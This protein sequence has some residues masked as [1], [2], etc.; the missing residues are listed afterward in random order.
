MKTI[1]FLVAVYVIWQILKSV[2]QSQQSKKPENIIVSYEEESKRIITSVRKDKENEHSMLHPLPDVLM[3]LERIE[4]WYSRLNEIDKHDNQ[5][6]MKDAEDWRD[7]TSYIN[8][9]H[10]FYLKT[11]ADV[12]ESDFKRIESSMAKL[13]ELEKR[14]SKKLNEDPEKYWKLEKEAKEGHIW[15]K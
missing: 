4:N 6:L 14:W 1:Y 15:K 13:V 3:K 10:Y 7:A 8:D 5:E 9:L 12:D 2:R 11:N